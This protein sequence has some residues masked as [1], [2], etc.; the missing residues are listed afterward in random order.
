[1]RG[2]TAKWRKPQ[3]MKHMQQTCQ[4]E[5]HVKEGDNKDRQGQDFA[6]NPIEK[7]GTRQHAIHEGPPLMQQMRPS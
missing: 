4:P 5:K 1:M 7:A 2:N 3:G 6:E